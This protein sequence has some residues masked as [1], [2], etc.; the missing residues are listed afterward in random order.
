MRIAPRTRN[1]RDPGPSRRA[2]HATVPRELTEAI[3]AAGWTVWRSGPG[4]FYVIDCADDP[5]RG[6]SLAA[7]PVNA[8]WQARMAGLLDPPPDYAAAG[9]RAALPVV[10]PL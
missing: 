3:R 5:V 6:G 9:G 7:D 2:G 4:L 10:W 8:G 1:R